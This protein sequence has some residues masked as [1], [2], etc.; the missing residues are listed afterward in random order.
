MKWSYHVDLSEK[1]VKDRISKF[2]SDKRNKKKKKGGIDGQ[3]QA[4][5]K[6]GKK[7]EAGLKRASDTA[8]EKSLKASKKPKHDPKDSEKTQKPKKKMVT[9]PEFVD[10]SSSGEKSSGENSSS[11]SDSNDSSVNNEDNLNSSIHL[12]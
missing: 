3:M 1:T 4:K 2:T 5:N 12:D 6:D 9:T 10:S 11:E 8:P 7:D